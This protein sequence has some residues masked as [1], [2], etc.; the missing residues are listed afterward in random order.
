MGDLEKKKRAKKK[1][2]VSVKGEFATTLERD[3]KDIA[4]IYRG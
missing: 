4:I 3:K 1:K 2:K